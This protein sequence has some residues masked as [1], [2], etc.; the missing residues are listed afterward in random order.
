MDTSCRGKSFRKGDFGWEEHPVELLLGGAAEQLQSQ[1]DIIARQ[2]KCRNLAIS[3]GVK[4]SGLP[5]DPVP[6]RYD[7]LLK[8]GSRFRHFT[9]RVTNL[10]YR[11][12]E[13]ISK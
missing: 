3:P 8:L 9:G 6:A 13:I 11:I 12:A 1:M 7:S 10:P 5:P 2:I 4:M